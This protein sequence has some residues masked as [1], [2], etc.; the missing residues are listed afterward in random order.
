MVDTGLD[1]LYMRRV[2]PVSH[3]FLIPAPEVDFIISYFTKEESGAQ[4]GKANAP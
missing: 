3:S 2:S 4:R 1:F